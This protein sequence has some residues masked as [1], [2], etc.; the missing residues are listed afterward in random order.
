MQEVCGNSL[1]L[2]PFLSS[3]AALLSC[4]DCQLIGQ[5]A[6]AV[7]QLAHTHRLKAKFVYQVLF[8]PIANLEN[9]F[10]RLT[11]SEWQ[12]FNFPS[13]EV[14]VGRIWTQAYVPSQKDRESPLASPLLMSDEVTKRF[15]PTLIVATAVDI[16]RDD[17]H[18]F[19]KKLQKAGVSRSVI[20]LEFSIHDAVL[21]ETTRTGPTAQTAIRAAACE[22][23]NALFPSGNRKGTEK[24][25]AKCN[26]TRSS[27]RR[28]T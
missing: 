6:P 21:W 23:N 26:G 20:Q 11:F 16:L 27:K 12:L 8:S 4:A 28:R 17:G 9:V 1:Q 25:V 14:P 15:P 5:L 3:S 24:H 13:L 2:H 22:L 7:I 19:G 18:A 10:E